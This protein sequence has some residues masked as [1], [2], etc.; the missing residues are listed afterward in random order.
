MTATID[1]AALVAAITER[2][3]NEVTLVQNAYADN[4]GADMARDAYIIHCAVARHLGYVLADIKAGTFD[5]V[6]RVAA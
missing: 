3:A 6:A 1:T 2:I 5:A 4:A